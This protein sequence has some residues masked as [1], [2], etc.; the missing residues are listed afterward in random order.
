MID[1]QF[2]NENNK[3][4]PSLYDEVAEKIANTLV[5]SNRGISFGVS[6][7][8][9]RNLFDET[10]RIRRR[11]EETQTSWD[12]VKP[13]VKLLKSKTSYAVARA[14]K[15][16]PKDSKYYTNLKGFIHKSIDNI[17]IEQDFHIFCNLFEAVYGFYYEKGG[18]ETK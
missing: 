4:D 7:H 9:L 13:M 3:V 15:N 17:K 11:L 12:D 8:Q 2:Y 5:T 1:L 10:K 14:K 16:N 18:A 6:R